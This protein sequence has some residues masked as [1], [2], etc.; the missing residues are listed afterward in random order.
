MV[1]LT[2]KMVHSKSSVK[3]REKMV[4]WVRYQMSE[5]WAILRLQYKNHYMQVDKFSWIIKQV[6]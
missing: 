5:I 4:K 6:L 3:L 2:S 1:F